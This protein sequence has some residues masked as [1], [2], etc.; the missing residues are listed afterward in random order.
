MWYLYGIIGTFVF[1]IASMWK[2]L[3]EEKSAETI[4]YAILGAGFMSI[5][6]PIGLPYM[7]I[8]FLL[9]HAKKKK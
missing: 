5:F 7:I 8:I 2:D 4:N 9:Q 6:W 1:I 3:K